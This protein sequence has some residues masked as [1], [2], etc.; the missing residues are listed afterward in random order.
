MALKVCVDSV[1]KWAV[2]RKSAD[3]QPDTPLDDPE[4]KIVTLKLD[5]HEARVIVAVLQGWLNSMSKE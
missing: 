5:D 4:M 1:T 3:I 2:I